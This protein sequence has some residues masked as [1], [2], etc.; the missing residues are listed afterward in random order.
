MIGPAVSSPSFCKNETLVSELLQ[1]FPEA[2]LNSDG[3]ILKGDDLVGFLQGYQS[4]IVGT[5]PLTE[6]VISQLPDLKFVSKY[7][8]G[9]DNVDEQALLARGIGLG[10]SGGVNRRSVSE[11]A[12]SFLIGLCRNLYF[13]SH[14]LKAGEWDKRGGFQLTGKTVGII[15][16]GFVGEDLIRLLQPFEC[17]ILINDILDKSQ[18]CKK[19][20][21]RQVDL[22]ELLKESDVISLHVPLT[23]DTR[24]MVNG[25]FLEAMQSHAFLVNTS[26]GPVVDERALAAALKQGLIAGAAIDVYQVEPATDLEFLSLPN[27]V[28]TPHI[29][30]NAKEA[31][32]AMGRSAIEH[33]RAWA[34]KR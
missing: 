15:G 28:C 27:L 9:L 33:L 12:L 23:S 21:V 26:R 30:G 3:R 20:G 32:L 6:E 5:D 29:G 25:E 19:F 8:V 16:C 4:I 17:N 7:G 34:A 1:A 24:N 14:K 10:W 31:V 2:H 18:I 22:A 13:T 11:M